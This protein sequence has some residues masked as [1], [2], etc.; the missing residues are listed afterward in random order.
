MS[1]ACPHAFPEDLAL[2]LGE[3][4]QQSGHRTPRGCSQVQR[5]G[6]QYEANAEMFKF[7]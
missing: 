3:D 7:L 6:Q 2:E 1:E 4:G 5:L